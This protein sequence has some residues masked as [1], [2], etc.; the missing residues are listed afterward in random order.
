MSTINLARALRKQA[1]RHGLCLTGTPPVPALSAYAH[2]I[3][4]TE[5]GVR[6]AY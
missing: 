6:S 3:H 2:A 5:P 4:R 1:A